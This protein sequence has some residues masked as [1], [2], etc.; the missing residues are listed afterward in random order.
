MPKIL[1][2]ARFTSPVALNKPND[3]KDTP[4]N[5]IPKRISFAE[6]VRLALQESTQPLTVT[7]LAELLSRKHEKMYDEVTVRNAVNELV[8]SNKITY[9]TETMEER[10]LR[11]SNP[12]LAKRSVL[13]KL[14]WSPVE[15][16]PARTVPDAV[17]GFT[18]YGSGPVHYKKYTGKYKSKRHEKAVAEIELEDISSYETPVAPAKNDM[19]DYLIEKM[20]AERVAEITSGAVK[21][22]AEAR[23]ELAR[24][25]E[26]IKSSL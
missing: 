22:L 6:N 15:E 20:V 3:K 13:A 9:R 14:Y 2:L 18:L 12:V 8:G 24:L 4:I 5:T 10:L 21:E 11:S 19:V 7:E 1:E 25:R 23:A 26:F 16:V 17:P